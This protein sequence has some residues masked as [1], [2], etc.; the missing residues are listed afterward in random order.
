MI[1]CTLADRFGDFTLFNSIL[2]EFVYS[3]VP[4]SRAHKCM[5]T[6]LKFNVRL[7]HTFK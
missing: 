2:C 5:H 1:T 6:R 3:L 4:Y 7:V